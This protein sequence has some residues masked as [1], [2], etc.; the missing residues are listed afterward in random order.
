MTDSR[1]LPIDQ[2][3][4]IFGKSRKTILRWIQS[5]KLP[6]HKEAVDGREQWRVDVDNVQPVQPIE[7]D[8]T[9]TN[10]LK[11]LLAEKDR[12]IVDLLANI[13]T[14]KTELADINERL[15][16]AHILIGQQE[17]KLKALPGPRKW[18]QFWRR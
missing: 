16:E 2:A 8:M 18:W 11:Y 14:L 1:G 10:A 3:A 15:R 6:A 5:G 17:G 9:R 13:S 7:Q 4:K 12:R